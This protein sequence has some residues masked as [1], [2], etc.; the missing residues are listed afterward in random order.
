MALIKSKEK[1]LEECLVI[2]K[3]LNE[4]GLNDMPELE[5]LKKIMKDYI[6]IGI[7]YSGKIKLDAI[8]RVVEYILCN[9]EHIESKVILRRVS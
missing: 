2:R 7:S 4:L 6:H 8:P 5:E 1:R 3:Q 9:K